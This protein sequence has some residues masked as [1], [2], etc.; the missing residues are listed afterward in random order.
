MATVAIWFKERFAYVASILVLGA[1]ILLVQRY[2]LDD[3]WISFRYAA[4][5]NK[6]WGLVYNYGERVEGYTNFLWT[7][8][9]GLLMRVGA[10]PLGFAPSRGAFWGSNFASGL[11][12]YAG[13]WL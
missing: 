8:L 4:N 1:N 7:I 3:A 6:G 9:I 2:A 10:E 11:S 12:L 13:A 5:W